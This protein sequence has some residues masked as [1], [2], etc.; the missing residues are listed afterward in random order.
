MKK[1]FLFLTL[2]AFGVQANENIYTGFFSQ[3]AL[4]GYDAVSYFESGKAEKGSK[5]FRHNY[6]GVD[7]YFSTAAHL[8]KFEEN[9]ESYRPQYGGFCAWAVATKKARAPGDPKYWKIIDGK[10]YLNYDKKV[11]QDWLKSP[12]EFIQQGDINWPEMVVKE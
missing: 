9:P 3:T 8:K 10:L 4:G 7:W 12:E 1:L 2:F 11:Q 5:Q 6:L